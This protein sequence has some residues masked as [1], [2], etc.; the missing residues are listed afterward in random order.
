MNL[1]SFLENV[2][3]QEFIDVI[4]GLLFFFSPGFLIIALFDPA[5][6][7]NLDAVKL[8]LLSISISTPFVLF[9]FLVCSWIIEKFDNLKEAGFAAMFIAILL[10]GF[11]LY[12]SL[13]FAYFGNIKDLHQLVKITLSSDP[14]ILFGFYFGSKFSSKK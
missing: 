4:V 1:K 2:K 9:N 5:L 3:K 10:S 11:V 6:F 14:F 12:I 8:T 7:L 13:A